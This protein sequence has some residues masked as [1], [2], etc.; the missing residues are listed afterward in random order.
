MTKAWQTHKHA[1]SWENHP[2]E[3]RVQVPTYQTDGTC[4]RG[5]VLVIE[6]L[7]LILTLLVAGAM[8]GLTAGLFGNG[9]GFVVVPALLFVFSLLGYQG[10]HLIFMAVGTSLATIVVS[11][12]RAARTHQELG[13]VDREVLRTWAPWLTLGVGVGVYLAASTDARGLYLIFAAG[14]GI[15]SS[16][17]LFPGMLDR[18]S[19]E[20]LPAG[21]PR[22]S[23]ATCLGGFSALLGIGGGTPTIITMTLCGRSIVQ[24]V[25]TAAGVGFIIGLVG[26]LG[27]ALIGLQQ[28]MPEAPPWSIGFVNLPALASISAASLM[29]APVGARL[30]HRLDAVTLKRMFGVYLVVVSLTMFLKSP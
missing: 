1:R 27:F 14:V 9:G 20:N 19:F 13:S 16:Y 4:S 6:A 2:K 26:C 11:S 18:Y 8:A 17:F 24:A 15:Y 5:A 22:A 29:T 23:L 7:L 21:L 3:T 28:A 30:A 12:F 25:G 10:D